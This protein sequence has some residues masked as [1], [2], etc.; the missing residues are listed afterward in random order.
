[1]QAY[2]GGQ[3]A[4]QQAGQAF[5]ACVCQ[6]PGTCATQCAQSYCAGQAPQPNDACEQC[7]GTATQC[8]QQADQICNATPDCASILSCFG[9]SQC[10]TKP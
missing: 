2:P 10:S 3:Q 5:G 9:A 1:V 7:L 8:E 6:T 4:F